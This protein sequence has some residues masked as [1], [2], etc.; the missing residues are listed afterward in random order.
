M[1]GWSISCPCY[2]YQGTL[3]FPNPILFRSHVL[4]AFGQRRPLCICH[5]RHLL[6]T[7][8]IPA[9]APTRSLSLNRSLDIIQ[10][11]LTGFETNTEADSGVGHGHLG[12]LLGGE[13][14]KDG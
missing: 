3:L 8:K 13:E 9:I 4:H 7:F 2:T 12:T 1:L 6:Q 5:T 11:I 14:T 10:Q